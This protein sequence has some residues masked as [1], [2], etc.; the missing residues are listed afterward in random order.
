[1]SYGLTFGSVRI[2]STW[3][4]CPAPFLDLV[5]TLDEMFPPSLASHVDWGG[6]NDLACI[7][8]IWPMNTATACADPPSRF[9]PQAFLAMVEKLKQFYRP[10]FQT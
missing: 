3:I 1:M 9:D 5:P 10:E 7:A 2:G 4:R 6:V 8:D